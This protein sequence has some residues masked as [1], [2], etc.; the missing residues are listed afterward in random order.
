M[1]EITLT[2]EEIQVVLNALLNTQA[3]ISFNAIEVINNKLSSNDG[4]KQV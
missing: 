4:G 1:K 2:A 3:R